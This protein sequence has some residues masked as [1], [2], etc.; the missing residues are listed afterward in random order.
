MGLRRMQG[1]PGGQ[2]VE[3]M[4]ADGH[5]CGRIEGRRPGEATCFQAPIVEPEAVGVPEQDLQLVPLAITEDKPDLAQRVVSALSALRQR[6]RVD[7]S[8]RPKPRP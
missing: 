1:Q 7:A 6:Q 8:R 5:R 2:P 4:P 3:L